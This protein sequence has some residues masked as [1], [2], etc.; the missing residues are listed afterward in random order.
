M[1]VPVNFVCLGIDYMDD[2][3]DEQRTTIEKQEQKIEDGQRG[4]RKVNQTKKPTVKNRIR[5]S[6]DKKNENVDFSSVKASFQVGLARVGVSEGKMLTKSL[7]N[8]SL[9]INDMYRAGLR[10]ELKEPLTNVSKVVSNLIEFS[11]KPGFEDS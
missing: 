9:D 2:S 11:K 4:T 10:E 8:L 1:L 7:A 3:E 6:A 5:G